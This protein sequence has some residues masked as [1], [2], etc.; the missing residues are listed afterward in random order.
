MEEKRTPLKIAGSILDNIISIADKFISGLTTIGK[1]MGHPDFIVDVREQLDRFAETLKQIPQEKRSISKEESDALLRIFIAAAKPDFAKQF[2]NEIDTEVYFFFGKFLSEQLDKNSNAKNLSHEYLNLFRFPSLLRRIYEE[3]RWEPL[4]HE[5]VT[6]SKYNTS[7]LFNQRLRDYKSKTLFKVIHGKTFTDYSW[8]KS[9]NIINKYKQAFYS[10]IAKIDQSSSENNRTSPGNE[11]V[12]FLLENCVEMALLDLACLSCGIVNVMIPGNS[13]TEHIRFILKQSKASF[14]IAHD[15][16]QL[17]K[18]KS[19]KNEIPDLKTVI[20]L[21]G[22][23]SEDWVISFDEFLKSGKENQIDFEKG[24]DDLAT[25]MYT[26]GTTG[27]PKG[28]MFSQ[29]N[30]VYKRFCRAM[31]I[32]E[33]GDE[34]R[35]ICF[36]PLY[37]T[38]G[39]YLEMMGC[40]FW[41]AEY[42]F[43]EN[44]SVEAMISNMKL[45]KPTVFISIPKKWMQLYDYVTSKVDIEIDEHQ[46]IKNELDNVTG[47]EL[48][49]GLSAAGYLPPDIFMFFQKYGVELMSGFGMTEATGGITMTP[50]KQYKPNS[51]GKALPGIGIKLADDGEIMVKGHYVMLGYYNTENSET[52]TEDGW[53]PTGDIMKMDEDGFIQIIDR[54]KEIYKNIKGETVAPQKIENLFRDFENVKQVFLVGDHR[55]FNTVLIFPNLD[56]KSSPLHDMDEK[57]RQEY[58][59]S[60]IVTVNK[61]LAPFE[62]ILDF[63]II[64]RAFDDAHGELTPKQTYKRKVIEENF[65]EVIESMYVRNDTG[66]Y[67][68]TTEVRIPNWFLREKGCLGRDVVASEKGIAIPKQNLSLNLSKTEDNVFRIGSFN[69]KVNTPFIDFQ[70]LLIDPLL[71][72]GNNELTLFTGDAIIQWRRQ[73]KESKQIRFHSTAEKL[74]P[75]EKEIA[76]FKKISSSSE[77]SLL[78]I[79]IAYLMFLSDEV[80]NA[81]SALDYFNQILDDPKNLNYNTVFNILSRPVIS[82]NIEIKRKQF[83]TIIKGANERKFGELFKSFLSEDKNL[84]DSALAQQVAASSKG[85]KRLAHIEHFINNEIAKTDTDLSANKKYLTNLFELITVYGVTHPQLYRRIRRFLLYITTLTEI[86]EIKELTNSSLDSLTAGFREWLGQNQKIAVDYETS[87]EYQWEDVISFEEGIDP[88]DRL[89]IKNAISKTA[90]MR[91]AVFMLSKGFQI[92]LDDVLPGGIWISQ[93]ESRLDKSIYRI[94]VQ[95]RFHGAFDLT[96]HLNKNLPPA[97]VKE[98]IKWLILGGMN[99]KGERLLPH[100]GGYWEE[101][102]LWTEA[103]VPRASVAKFL[104]KETRKKDDEA[105]QRL[106]DLWPH[107]VWNSSAAYMNFW[108]V[109]NYHTQLAN[110]HPENITVPTHDYQTGTLLYSVSKRIDS[111]SP[112]D[113]FLNFYK[114]YIKETLHKFSFLDKKSIWNYIF[115]GITECEGE[116]KAIEIIKRFIEEVKEDATIKNKK[117]ILFRAEEF[118]RSIT[119]EGFVPRNL[120][121][122][123]KRFHRWSLLNKDADI[124]AQSQMLYELYETYQLFNFEKEYM[125]TR[126]VFF[127]NTAFSNSSESLKNAIVNIIKKQRRGE[128]TAD[129]SQLLYAELHSLPDLTE[130]EKFFL[131]RLNYPY[132][133]PKDTVEFVGSGSFEGDTSNL[134]IQLTDEEGNPFLIRSP[135]SPKEIS[136][137][138]S[139]FLESNLIVNF[140][141]EHR[142]LVALSERGFIIGGLFYELKDEQTAHMEKIVVSSRYRKTGISENLMNEFLKRLKSEHIRNVTTGFFRPEYFYKFGFKVEKKYSGL[143]KEL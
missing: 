78:G 69:Y 119:E 127:L 84:L 131:T 59:S 109:T 118:V 102:E 39:R 63:N 106:R 40:V 76:D 1:K 42:C 89:R 23:S 137:L 18:I 62:R 114:L 121:F 107:F 24:I 126:P 70:Q 111:D 92:R 139:L 41:A 58:F 112:K 140:R 87:E 128:V 50:W 83:S 120:F 90:V 72:L 10:T 108:A 125:T 98:E 103:F 117:D 64:D 122:A 93:L 7:V 141:P 80:D 15:E 75:E 97:K 6:K 94:T 85:E 29:T 100:F 51:L 135:V 46:K 26:S 53:L 13:V 81:I 47:G 60:L 2:M 104:E 129:K 105:K 142:F 86:H 27:E 68:G 35:F 82:S 65:K 43:L 74:I 101:Y 3:K 44:P 77:Y 134:V 99:R 55:A 11:K 61:F 32:P 16:K 38:F 91:E 66:V 49:W 19:I 71:W 73:V 37:H 138:H 124:D 133:K 36:L 143:V 25:I 79:H 96:I 33:I 12:A 48:K 21:E 130:D 52:F 123:I 115:A 88:E 54:K 31:A 95:T 17:S 67:V 4:I 22:N 8:E 56:D 113:F 14:L 132:L 116:I 28:I 30:I 110:P 57:Q 9:A 34:D 45:V 20:L 5:L 136:R